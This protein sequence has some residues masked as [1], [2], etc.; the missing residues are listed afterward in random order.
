MSAVESILMLAFILPLLLATSWVREELRMVEPRTR[1]GFGV[2]AFF[3]AVAIFFVMIKMLPEPAEI[4]NNLLL[5]T[6]LMGGASAS[7][8]GLILSIVLISSSVW[9]TFKRW[10]FYRRDVC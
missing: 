2:V 8:S 6:L 10:K 1:F 3:G 7:A 5:Q 4:E 9:Q